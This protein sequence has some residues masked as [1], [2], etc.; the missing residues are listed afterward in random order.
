[1]LT[2]W[3][4]KEGKQESLNKIQIPSRKGKIKDLDGE[5]EK[6]ERGEAGEGEEEVEKGE[7][8]KREKGTRKRR[9]KEKRRERA[10]T[11]TAAKRKAW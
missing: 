10:H 9:G 8:G 7:R 1:M 6:G 4:E 2:F 11:Q 5:K 3:Q